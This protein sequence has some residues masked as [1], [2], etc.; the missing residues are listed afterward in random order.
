MSDQENGIRQSPFTEAVVPVPS[1][2]SGDQG[3]GGG[4]DS[5]GGPNGITASPWKSPTC[6]TPSGMVESG[7]FGNPSRFSSVDGSTHQG[8]SEAAT[9]EKYT[10][11]IDRK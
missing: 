8:A 1:A 4:L 3:I 5:D 7:P 9:I 6:P 2:T 10:N 11:T